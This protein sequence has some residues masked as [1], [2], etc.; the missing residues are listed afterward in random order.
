VRNVKIEKLS[1]RHLSKLVTRLMKTY[2]IDAFNCPNVANQKYCKNLR[3]LVFRRYV[4]KSITYEPWH[5]LIGECLKHA[6][7]LIDEF[8]NLLHQ[9]NDIKEICKW[10]KIIDISCDKLNEPVLLIV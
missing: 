8:F 3:Y 1:K 5:D 4:E 10:M 9:Y 7:Y 2:K 6:D